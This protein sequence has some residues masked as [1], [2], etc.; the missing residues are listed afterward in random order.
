MP[1]LLN[2]HFQFQ[3]HHKLWQHCKWFLLRLNIKYFLVSVIWVKI[4]G[5]CQTKHKTC[6]TCGCKRMLCGGVIIKHF[7][8]QDISKYGVI[9]KC[10]R[11]WDTLVKCSS[12]QPLVT[13]DK[14]LSKAALAKIAIPHKV[15]HWRTQMQNLKS[16]WQIVFWIDECLSETTNVW[17]DSTRTGLHHGPERFFKPAL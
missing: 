9:R 14:Y 3:Q 15:K 6:K 11:R 17:A 13:S 12:W 16:E 8:D 5:S 4:W 10:L 7:T 1:N 2:E